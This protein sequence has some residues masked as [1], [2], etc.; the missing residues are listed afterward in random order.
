MCSEKIERSEQEPET[1]AEAEAEP[2]ELRKGG[3][4]EMP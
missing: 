3:K 2:G 1:E 4:R